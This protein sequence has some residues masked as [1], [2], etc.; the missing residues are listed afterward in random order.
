M[1]SLLLTAFLL[2][3]VHETLSELEWNPESGRVEVAL[4][5]SLVDEEWI[6]RQHGPVPAGEERRKWYRQQL[7][8]S[9]VFDPVDIKT[10]APSG[11]PIHWLGRKEEGAHAWWFFEVGGDKTPP[12]SLRMSLLFDRDSNYRHRVVML[13]KKKDGSANHRSVELSAPRPQVELDLVR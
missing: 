9:M 5:L 13:G 12:K 10:D 2:H 6:K 11:R 1:S 4:R 3:P 7:A 8:A